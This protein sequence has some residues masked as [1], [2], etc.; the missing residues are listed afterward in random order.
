[1]AKSADQQAKDAMKAATDADQQ[2]KIGQQKAEEAIVAAN[3]GKKL[4]EQGIGRLD[5]VEKRILGLDNF[6]VVADE[7]VYFD[8]EKDALSK[9][10]QEL[11]NGL[12]TR[13]GTHHRY[14]I[15]VQGFTDSSG[16]SQFNLELS[17]R[18][19]GG[20]SKPHAATQ[21]RCTATSFCLSE[22]PTMTTT[23]KGKTESPR[24]VACFG[25]CRYARP[26]AARHMQ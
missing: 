25:R 8:F 13:M 1:L 19:A 24:E 11:L 5:T 20:C 17:R 4:A 10:A 18:R 3:A 26:P 16:S 6:A 15:E 7:T 12:A 23:S 22:A 21:V 2:A 9:D 14:L